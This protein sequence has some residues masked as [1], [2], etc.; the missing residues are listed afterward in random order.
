M[1][2]CPATSARSCSQHLGTEIHYQP[3]SKHDASRTPSLQPTP[4]KAVDRPR[5][6]KL[7]TPVRGGTPPCV[8]AQG[9][10]NTMSLLTLASRVQGSSPEPRPFDSTLATSSVV[11]YCSFCYWSRKAGT[12]YASKGSE[13]ASSGTADLFGSAPTQHGLLWG[14]WSYMSDLYVVSWPSPAQNH[15]SAFPSDPPRKKPCGKTP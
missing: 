1:E 14:D 11:V 12:V 2:A 3:P 5:E 9:C 4:N 8:S 15:F 7:Q 13:Q 6:L 10:T